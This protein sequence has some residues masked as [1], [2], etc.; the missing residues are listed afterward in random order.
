[1]AIQFSLA[2]TG[3]AQEYEVKYKGINC[4]LKQC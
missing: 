4:H 1:M 3:F 2:V